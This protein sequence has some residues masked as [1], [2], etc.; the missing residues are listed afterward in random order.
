MALLIKLKI[1]IQVLEFFMHELM[2][3]RVMILFLFTTGDNN[4]RKSSTSQFRDAE[5]FLLTICIT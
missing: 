4:Y 3:K 2:D 5:L 1:Q